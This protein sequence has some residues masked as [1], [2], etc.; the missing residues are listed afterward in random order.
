[1][2]API[3]FDDFVPG[4]RMGETHMV[5]RAEFASQWER[6]F[7]APSGDADRA[8]EGASIA[9]VMMMRAYMAVVSP[10]PPGNMHA[11]QQIVLDGVPRLNEEVRT[12]VSCAAKE[13]RR[14]RRY[15]ELLVDATG[16]GGRAIY[17][18]RMT[19]IWAR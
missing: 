16:D 8:A 10:R 11:R 14:D 12:E 3:L 4:A 5:Y 13:I 1:M 18:G 6:I 7:G 2:S 17:R 19:L 9:T 15:V